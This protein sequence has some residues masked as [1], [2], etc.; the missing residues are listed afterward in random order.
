[1][2]TASTVAIA[3]MLALPIASGS[4]SGEPTKPIHRL[5]SIRDA[6]LSDLADR[7]TTNG[8]DMTEQR[9]AQ[10]PNFPNFGNWR[11]R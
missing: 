10:F 7:Q 1:M 5:F 3:G 9:I 11:N 6:Y 4:R 8:P 2:S